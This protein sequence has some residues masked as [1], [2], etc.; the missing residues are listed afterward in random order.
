[1]EIKKR[2][3]VKVWNTIDRLGARQCHRKFAYG[4]MRNR[5]ILQDE[6]DIL[7]DLSKPTDGWQ[8]FEEKR[9]G[10]CR[11]LADKDENGEPKVQG[12]QFLV[13][14]KKEELDE[15]IEKLREE[16]KDDLDEF[17][18]REKEFDEI[19]DEDISIDIYKIK[20]SLFPEQ[21]SVY[22]LEV[23]DDFIINDEEEDKED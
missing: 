19:L 16:H 17:E 4:L 8:A 22:E 20:L 10:I 1:M 12:N 11:E 23:L 6:I 18:R 15:R 9:I 5:K 13:T 3:L 21:I 14:E 2:Q 7:Q